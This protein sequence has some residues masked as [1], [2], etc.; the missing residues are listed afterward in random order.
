M[1]S[2]ILRVGSTQCETKL[3]NLLVCL[4]PVQTC[5]REVR[6]KIDSF[7]ESVSDLMSEALSKRKNDIG[8][9]GINSAV[10][11]VSNYVSGSDLDAMLVVNGRSVDWIAFN[12][13]VYYEDEPLDGFAK[14]VED[15]FPAVMKSAVFKHKEHINGWE[16]QKFPFLLASIKFRDHE[17]EV[18]HN[19]IPAFR[20]SKDF[21]VNMQPLSL[22]S[23]GS[24]IENI[25]DCTN[26]SFSLFIRMATI[27]ANRWNDD[28]TH[29]KLSPLVIEAAAVRDQLL[30]R[31]WNS[32]SFAKLFFRLFEIIGEC[33]MFNKPLTHMYSANKGKDLLLELRSEE[34]LSWIKEI[35]RI[36]KD[37]NTLL[38]ELTKVLKL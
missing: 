27:Y 28:E 36:S 2:K 9:V 18:K 8:G 19:L 25:D 14:I 22:L 34:F 30:A 37:E 21:Y 26:G 20:I 33:L 13:M 16:I 35:L 5:P 32:T 1:Y 11:H 29:P 31:N 6:S 7:H 15:I 24:K 23:I 3:W 10:E 12:S 4:P 38:R 17:N